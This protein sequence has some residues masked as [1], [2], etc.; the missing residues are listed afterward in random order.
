MIKF[1]FFPQLPVAYLT[2]THV[3]SF[4]LFLREFAAFSWYVL[5]NFF[6]IITQQPTFIIMLFLVYLRFNII[7]ADWWLCFVQLL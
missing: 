4:I 1:N 5:D 2:Q 6:S 7:D 3:F